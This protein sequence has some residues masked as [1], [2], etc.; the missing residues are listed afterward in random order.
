MIDEYLEPHARVIY[1]H[2][3]AHPAHDG[4]MR[5]A[6]WIKASGIREFTFRDVRRRGWKEFNIK[7]DNEAIESALHYLEARGWIKV[8][9]KATGSRGGRPTVSAV[10]NP[11]S[12]CRN[13]PETP[14]GTKT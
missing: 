4:A 3:G 2:L 10:V 5:I 13:R 7:R 6:E 8:Q 11:V 9:Q 1:Q 14:R 12:R